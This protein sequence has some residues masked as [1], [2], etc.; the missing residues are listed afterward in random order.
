MPYNI[1]FLICRPVIYFNIGIIHSKSLKAVLLRTV[2]TQSTPSDFELFL[3]LLCQ[4]AKLSKVV[5]CFL[6]ANNA[7]VCV[8]KISVYSKPSIYRA[9]IYRVFDLPRFWF[10]AFSIYRV[11]D[12]SCFRFN[13]FSIHRVFD[14]QCLEL[15]PQIT[16]FMHKPMVIKIRFT[17]QFSFPQSTS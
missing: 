15:F 1:L 5:N 8:N 17:V 14:S 13:V 10:T 4:S 3:P 16:I 9:L 11:F 7:V 6:V 12:S 2:I